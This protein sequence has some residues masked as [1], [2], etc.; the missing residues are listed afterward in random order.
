FSR[1]EMA[2]VVMEKNQYK[3]RLIE[4]QEALRR[5]QQLRASREKTVEEKPTSVWRRFHRLFGLTKDPLAPPTQTPKTRATPIPTTTPTDVSPPPPPTPPLSPSLPSVSPR[6]RKR[7]LYRDIRTHVWRIL[8]KKQLHGWSLPP[9]GQEALSPSLDLNEVPVLVQLRILDQKESTSKLSCAVAVTPDL[10]ADH[11]CLVWVVSGPPSSSDVTV[12]DPVQ[13]NQVLDQFHL[14]PPSPALCI[15]TVPPA[16]NSPSPSSG[17]VWI[18]TQDG[19]LLVHSASHNRRLCLQSTNLHESVHS[20]TY[21]QGQVIAGLA[22]GT[23]ALFSRN[24]GETYPPNPPPRCP[25]TVTAACS[26]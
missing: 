15:N 16:E 20:I 13:S 2:R 14:P 17:T 6:L 21:S 10:S 7:E 19:S 23:L 25:H 22:N 8:G 11:T 24:S 18:G 26:Q 9:P 1:S 5:T 4:L 12:I 3:E